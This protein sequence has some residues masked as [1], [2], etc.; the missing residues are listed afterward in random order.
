MHT[1]V[2]IIFSQILGADKQK[3]IC[4]DKI[5]NKK[6]DTEKKGHFIVLSKLSDKIA[7]PHWLIVFMRGDI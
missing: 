2:I 1:H 5:F 6:L 7:F 4:I 3:S